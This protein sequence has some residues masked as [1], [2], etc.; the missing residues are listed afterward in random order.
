MNTLQNYVSPSATAQVTGNIINVTSGQIVPGGR[1][2][3][4][5]EDKDINYKKFFRSVPKNITKDYMNDPA[6]F[7]EYFKLH[8][9]EFGNWLNQ[10]ERRQFLSAGADSLIQLAEMLGVSHSSMGLNRKLSIAFGAR[11]IGGKYAAHYE[12]KPYCIINI[13]KPHAQNGSFAHEFAHALDNLISFHVEKKQNGMV[14]LDFAEG[15]KSRYSDMMGKIFLS[16]LGKDG[17]SVFA[18]KLEKMTDYY[19]FPPEIF[20]R[21]FEA[22]LEH[23]YGKPTN[24]MLYKPNYS[25]SIYP[26][27]SLLKLCA[28]NIIKFAKTA[29]NELKGIDTFQSTS[30]KIDVKEEKAPEPVEVKKE[31]PKVEKPKVEVKPVDEIA[32]SVFHDKWQNIYSKVQEIAKETKNLDDKYY[33]QIQLL[34]E[35]SIKAEKNIS[36]RNKAYKWLI[37]D[38][39][40]LLL[41]EVLSE[42]KS[43]DKENLLSFNAMASLDSLD[44]KGTSKVKPSEI[45]PVEKP[46]VEKPKKEARKSEF[47]PG[48][49]KAIFGEKVIVVTP[50]EKLNAKYAIIDIEDLVQSNDAFTFSPNPNYPAMCQTRDYRMVKGEQN[51]VIEYSA[52]FEPKHLINSSPDATTGSPVVTND[53]IVLG[54][55]GRSMILKRVFANF[56]EKYENYRTTLYK[57]SDVLFGIPENEARSIKNPVLV[58]ILENAPIAE[59]SKYSNILNQ[60]NA[61]VYDEFQEG[62][63]IAKE[64]LGNPYAYK[65]IALAIAEQEAETIAE[66]FRDK[67]LNSMIIDT[68]KSIK[69]INNANMDLYVDSKT[70]TITERGKSI[71]VNA[72]LSS[73]LPDKQLLTEA[74]KYKNKLIA[75]LPAWIQVNSLKNDFNIIPKFQKALRMEAQRKASKLPLRDFIAQIG[76]FSEETDVMTI[77]LLKLLEYTKL[78]DFRNFAKYYSQRAM[79]N[80]SD[81][82]FG[83]VI[84]PQD[85]IFKWIQGNEIDG[86]SDLAGPISFDYHKAVKAQANYLF[87]GTPISVTILPDQVNIYRK[88]DQKQVGQI[89]LNTMKVVSNQFDMFGDA[90]LSVHANKV[91]A[92]LSYIK[93]LKP[94]KKEVVNQDAMFSS[95]DM[96][97]R[98]ER[99]AVAM[100]D[101]IQTENLSDMP[102]LETVEIPETEIISETIPETIDEDLY[103]S[104]DEIIYDETPEIEETNNLDTA[105]SI[106]LKPLYIPRAGKVHKLLNRLNSPFSMLIWGSQGSGKS[107][108]LLTL[109]DELSINGNCLLI[110]TEESTDDGRIGERTRRMQIRNKHKI[111]ILESPTLS[112]V[113]EKIESNKYKFV[114]ID[115]KDAFADEKYLLATYKKYMKD[116]VNFITIS[117]T[118]KDGEVYTGNRMY[119]FLCN[120]EIFVDK[121]GIAKVL[122]HRDAPKGNVIPVFSQIRKKSLFNLT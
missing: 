17:D 65:N 109:L 1:I 104:G 85:V 7:V 100:F 105:S 107:S 110:L 86:M 5:W 120:T 66:M 42:L 23:F 71:I 12:R 64:I 18:K 80:D 27:Q 22:T 121:N 78:K 88:S 108:L 113:V 36:Y 54:G 38:G 57:V 35:M 16:L 102:N 95:F 73:I 30:I 67:Q 117:H 63:S 20:A 46:K 56:K 8:S 10:E 72:L 43:Y 61:Q 11:G 87:D 58:R 41:K 119:A 115:S 116:G 81:N 6:S 122:K 48:T 50:T 21:S 24:S 92:L 94:V 40:T 59:C 106:P 68:L 44:R 101:K 51:K 70:Y 15:K 33:L 112:E 55:N 37:G 53:G 97:S 2:Q 83:E 111:D 52:Q 28:E 90:E 76:A 4:Y 25:D 26:P 47:K 31:I 74:D 99:G 84:T 13:T 39:D 118:T 75:T 79:E 89:D 91:D 32:Y 77:E 45:R 62:L 3:R 82:V 98:K 60:S 49:L 69:L 19:Q 14:S 9:V 114:A 29:I 93:G 34:E 103:T 96:P